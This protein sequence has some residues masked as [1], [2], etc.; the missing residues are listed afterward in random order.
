MQPTL[1]IPLI[2]TYKILRILKVLFIFQHSLL[3]FN[4]KEVV[5][6]MQKGEEKF[7]FRFCLQKM[8]IFVGTYEGT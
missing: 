7:F 5:Y 4:Q 8:L 6:F 3:Q 1:N 2:S